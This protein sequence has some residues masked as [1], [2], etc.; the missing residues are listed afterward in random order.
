M[1]KKKCIKCECE[2]ETRNDS[3]LCFCCTL[4]DLSDEYPNAEEDDIDLARIQ[5]GTY[6][7]EDVALLN[8][9]RECIESNEE[10]DDEEDGWDESGW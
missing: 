1:K 10:S 2:F 6:T 5:S 9:E 8:Q 3:D 7:D 4:R